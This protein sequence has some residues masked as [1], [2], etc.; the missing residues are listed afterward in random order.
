MNCRTGGLGGNAQRR[1]KF[2]VVDLVVLRAEERA[3]DLSGKVR[4]A[5]ARRRGRE[6]FERQI[7]AALKLQA[8]GDLGLIV[9]SER[10]HQRAL[11]PQLDIDAAR[12]RK[13]L[14]EDGPARLALAAE[15]DQRFFAGLGFAAGGEHAGRGMARAR[16]GLAAIEH[17]DGCARQQGARQCR[18]P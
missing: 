18:G 10:K 3:G 13:F 16:A 17:G 15:R 14:G 2:A 9:G 4:L 1:D 7:K 12:A 11:L 6:P 8:V 5:R